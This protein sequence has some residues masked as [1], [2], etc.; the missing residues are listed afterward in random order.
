MQQHHVCRMDRCAWKWVAYLDKL[1]ADMRAGG[2]GVSAVTA[3]DAIS[4]VVTVI[5]ASVAVLLAV[6]CAWPD[7]ER[8]R[9]PLRDHTRRAQIP[10]PA[11]W[12]CELPGRPL[13]LAEAHRAMQIHREHDCARKHVAMAMLVAEGRITPDSS[14]RHRQ[15][16]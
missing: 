9:G 8:C 4:S 1:V 2:R 6:A 12:S 11:H 3:W 16:A 5:A 15:W 13:T 10:W 7:S 14:R